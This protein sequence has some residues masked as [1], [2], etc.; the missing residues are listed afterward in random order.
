MIDETLDPRLAEVARLLENGGW[1]AEIFDAEWRLVWVSSEIKALVGEDDR[2]KL[3]YG[4]FLFERFMFEAWSSKVT[5]KSRLDVIVNQAPLILYEAPQHLELMLEAIEGEQ[6]DTARAGPPMKPPP[7]WA[8]TL[9]FVQE[10]LPPV[11]V[12]FVVARLTDENEILGR[13]VIYSPGLPAT[14]L[15]LVARGDAEMFKRMARLVNPGRH[16]AAVL[17]A[18]MQ[19]SGVMSRRLP[20][21][22]YFRII[23]AVTTAIDDI[24]IEHKGIVGKHAGDGVTAF[25]L[26]DDL[27]SRSAAARAAIEAARK[28]G[29]VC[30]RVAQVEELNGLLAAEDAVVN[31]GVHWGGMLYMGQLVTGGRLEVTALGDRVNEC[32]RIQ[33]SARDGEVLGSKSLLEHLMDEDAERLGLDPDT[34]TYR[35]IEELPDA[36]AKAKRDAGSLPVTRL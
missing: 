36:D 7:L 20:S 28:I 24:V 4:R 34:V 8:S 13:A 26:A 11:P 25:F 35:A 12:N 9:E 18:D 23:R 14:T 19:S 2:D 29:N 17:F 27:G 32:A 5:E 21:A 15:N 33:Q 6:L 22:A 3:G 31:V 16:A 1:A 30:E 10:D